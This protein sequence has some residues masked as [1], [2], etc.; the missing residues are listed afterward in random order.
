M[1]HIEVERKQALDAVRLYEGDTRI[2]DKDGNLLSM[3]TSD[4]LYGDENAY[5]T[6]N[7]L[8]FPGISNEISRIQKEGKKLNI[9]FLEK[10]EET[11]KL[12]CRIFQVMC[13]E[14]GT[15]EWIKAK[16]IE[17]QSAL[18]LLK[19]GQTLSFESASKGAYDKEFAKKD[20][21]ILI[22][23]YISLNVPY[24]DFERVLGTEYKNIEEREVLLAPFVDIEIKEINLTPIE[25]R[26]IRDLHG[27]PPKGKYQICTMGIRDFREQHKSMIL[28]E[29]MK[30]NILKR[31][32]VPLG[33]INAMNRGEWDMDFSEYIKW[34]E[35]LQK[36]LKYELSNRWYRGNNIWEN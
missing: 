33:A 31:K 28:L 9:V 30:H 14:H 4:P 36:Y 19:Q 8:L 26:T 17:R 2:R 34:K 11:L 20:G 7:T 16:R 6:L 25:Q 13:W 35:E 1:D 10:I 5:R 21:I 15:E 24:L 3:R 18:T 27:N 22:E 32:D 29:E 23:M 12:Y